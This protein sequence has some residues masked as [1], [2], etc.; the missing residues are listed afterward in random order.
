GPGSATDNAIARY[1][2]T[3]GKLLQNSGVTIDDSGNLNIAASAAYQQGG[4]GI[5]STSPTLYNTFVGEGAGQANTT[6]T[7]NTFLGYQA[8]YLNT[9][10]Q[11]ST[12]VGYEAGYSSTVINSNSRI[13]K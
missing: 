12:F 6:G 7:E 10:N 2:G 8:G 4:V 11:G 3:T 1:D 13:L 9:T 5:L